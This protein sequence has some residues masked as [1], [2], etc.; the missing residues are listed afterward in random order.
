RRKGRAR[1]EMPLQ[2]QFVKDGLAEIQLGGAAAGVLLKTVQILK[3]GP[4]EERNRTADAIGETQLG[5]SAR[6][7]SGAVV[8]SRDGNGCEVVK[9]EMAGQH[10]Q[11]QSSSRLQGE[12]FA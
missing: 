3:L 2:P 9:G 8:A 1:S 6:H 10:P 11:G 4:R 5:I 12:A 7:K